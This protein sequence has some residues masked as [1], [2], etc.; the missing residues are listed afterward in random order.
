MQQQQA[1]NGGIP[2][3]N[4]TRIPL[5]LQAVFLNGSRGVVVNAPP[6]EKAASKTFR[7][8]WRRR[9]VSTASGITQ[10]SIDESADAESLGETKGASNSEPKKKKK[11]KKKV[12]ALAATHM[13]VTTIG[14]VYSPN[15]KFPF[16]SSSRYL[17]Q[18]CLRN[19]T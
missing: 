2:S 18:H 17:Y 3:R 11:K 19:N 1:R 7:G 4:T 16:F 9:S 8:W 6:P 13:H 14:N 12:S 15:L 10:Q 5:S